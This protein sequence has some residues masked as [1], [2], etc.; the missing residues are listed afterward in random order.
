MAWHHLLWLQVQPVNFNSAIPFR[1]MLHT[2][3]AMT[4]SDNM[5]L[6]RFT[7][8]YKTRKHVTFPIQISHYRKWQ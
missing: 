5:H 7:S 6:H 4:A 1:T 8:L 2:V 3:S